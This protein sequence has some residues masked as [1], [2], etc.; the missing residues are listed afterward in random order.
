[1]QENQ[2]H[3]HVYRLASNKC[4]E[5]CKLHDFLGEIRVLV[6]FLFENPLFYKALCRPTVVY[7]DNEQEI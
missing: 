4:V 6:F 3:V 7:S 1:M 5:I 2:V